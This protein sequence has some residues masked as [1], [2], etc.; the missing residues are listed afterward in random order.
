MLEKMKEIVCNCVPVEPDE[1]TENSKFIS[2]LGMSS[3]DLVMVSV[4]LEKEFGI[5]IPDKLYTSVRTVGDL[6]KYIEE[7]K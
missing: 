4:E 7:N 1:I 2:D 5:S 3:L 6:M